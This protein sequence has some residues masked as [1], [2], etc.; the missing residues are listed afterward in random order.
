M[1]IIQT[2]FPLPVKGLPAVQMSHDN[3]NISFSYV[4]VP[5]KILLIFSYCFP[6]P[7]SK[8]SL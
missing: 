6:N 7:S 2:N 5:F 1:L 4:F 3:A 8:N